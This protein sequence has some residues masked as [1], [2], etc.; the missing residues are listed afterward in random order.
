MKDTRMAV[1]GLLLV[2]AKRANAEPKL[3]HVKE[4][5]ITIDE[6]TRFAWKDDAKRLAKEK[7]F[8]VMSVNVLAHN[9]FQG[10]ERPGFNVAVTVAKTVEPLQKKKPVTRGGLPVSVGGPSRQKTMAARRRNGR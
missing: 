6:M 3:V 1:I 8:E 9:H 4:L 7:G 10:T 2:D 5:G